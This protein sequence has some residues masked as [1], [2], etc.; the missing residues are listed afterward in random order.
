MYYPDDV[1]EDM[2]PTRVIRGSWMLPDPSGDHLFLHPEADPPWPDSAHRSTD[3]PVARQLNAQEILCQRCR[4]APMV[5]A[6]NSQGRYVGII[7]KEC[8][9]R[10]SQNTSSKRRPCLSKESRV[11]P[12][13]V[14][15]LGYTAHQRGLVL[16][17]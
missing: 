12:P 8:W 16:K 5:T 13:T 3:V 17:W 10:G 11:S 9:H 2:G 15:L 1:T 14:P 6:S 7:R 4:P